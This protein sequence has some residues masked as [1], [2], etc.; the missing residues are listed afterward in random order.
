MI[1]ILVTGAN[2]QLGK[3]L[4][5]VMV[6]KQFDVDFKSSLDLDI[7]DFKKVN[8]C[9]TRNKYD[10]VINCAAYTKVDK[11]EIET[12]HAFLINAKSVENIA[13]S[14]KKTGAI[15]IHISTDYVF[16]GDLNKPYTEDD[17]V[18]PINIYGKTKLAGE[19]Y[20]IKE[21]DRF[22]ILRTSWLYSKTHGNN[23]Y[24]FIKRSIAH[25]EQLRIVDNEFGK[26]T[27]TNLL[28][29]KIVYLILANSH[30][31]GVYHIAGEAVMN[32]YEFAENIVKEIA[33]KKSHLVIPVTFFDS[34]AKRPKNSV[35]STEKIDELTKG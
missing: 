12:E 27:E 31:Y 25:N 17:I 29:E 9:I 21:L 13:L 3:T 14:C 23:F 18:N 32:R 2:G 7:T 8:D 20:I 24:K 22:F 35:L 5:D 26:P 30:K 33:P 6:S 4:Q 10:Y 11:A 1:K 28:A 19:R 16:D 34:V 15:L